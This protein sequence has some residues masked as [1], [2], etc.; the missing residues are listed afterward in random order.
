L[1]V[2]HRRA[3]IAALAATLPLAGACAPTVS[4]YAT[5]SAAADSVVRAAISRE[6]EIQTANI[7]GNTVGVLPLRVRSADTTYASLGYGV[8]ALIAGDL[9]RSNRL[10]IVER[11]RLDAVLRELDLVRSGRVDTTTAPRVGRI[12]GA[13]RIIVGDLDIRSNGALQ[14]GST[15][16]NATSGAVD[17]ALSGNATVNQ[18]FD[19]EKAM[20]LRLFEALGVTLTPAER[21]DLEPRPTQSLA[22]LVAFSNGVR[23]ESVR[24][25]DAALL[26][27]QNARRLDPGFTEA[28]ERATTIQG[29][30][31]A[32]PDVAGVARVMSLSND[33]VNRPTPVL[34][35][36]GVDAPLTRQQLIT[37][38][39]NIR[40]P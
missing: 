26:H 28:R 33:L 21:R 9:A 34:F 10:V 40:T 3:W 13:R 14:L 38:T 2:M 11:L 35:G 37:I 22:A 27:Y 16:A 32:G 8:A 18:I 19:A 36:S 24:D 4:R 1:D 20:V 15:V 7:P 17:A 6:R 30:P 25:F 29:G 5:R 23:A 12:V 31:V 39:I